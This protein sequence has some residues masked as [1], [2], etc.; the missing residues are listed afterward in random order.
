[1]PK[2]INYTL[3]DEQLQQVEHAIAHDPRAE[4]VRRVTAIRLLHHGYTPEAAGKLLAASRASVQNWHKRWRDG[5]V[6][7]LANLPLPGRR[8]KADSTYREILER[9]VDTAPHEL[10]YAFSVWTLDRLI[11]HLDRETGIRLSEGRLAIWLKRW[12][13]VYR[14]P[15][16]D[17]K[18]KHDADVR[19]EV[20]AWLDEAKEQSKSGP[21]AFSLW[22][23]RPS[24]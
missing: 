18:H 13:Y 12:G 14:Q 16:V 6:N 21:A 1:M 23:K 11:Q 17:L 9:T 22:T 8:P 4:V 20:Q 3:T 24:V 15:K 10:G 7:A 5:G 2:R 19:A